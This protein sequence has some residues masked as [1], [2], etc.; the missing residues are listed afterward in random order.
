MVFNFDAAVTWDFVNDVPYW[1]DQ[2]VG[3]T[4]VQI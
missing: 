4:T 1:C 2:P 3:S